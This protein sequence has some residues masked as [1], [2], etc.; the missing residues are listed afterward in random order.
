MSNTPPGGGG[1]KINEKSALRGAFFGVDKRELS[2]A[3]QLFKVVV[4]D[5]YSL[6][7][8]RISWGFL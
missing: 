8:S 6:D 1:K 3:I 7:V 5:L 2:A 4:D